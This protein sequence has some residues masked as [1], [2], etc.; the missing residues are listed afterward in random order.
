MRAPAVR[1]SPG[2]GPTT[3]PAPR[4]RSRDEPRWQ[5]R[6]VLAALLR[7]AVLATPLAAS[8]AVAFGAARLLGTPAGPGERA[9]WWGGVLAASLGALVVFDR[10]ARRLLPLAALLELSLI[11]PD[12]APSRFGV[13]LRSGSTGRLRAREVEA[14]RRGDQEPAD[15]ARTILALAA[16][17]SVHDRDTRGHS[18]RVRAY[19][20]L[21][22]AELGLDADDR[23]RLRWAALLHDLGKLTVAAHTLHAPGD[24]SHDEWEALR[25]HPIEGAR[26]A[27]PLRAWLGPWALAIEQHHERFDG[28]GYPYGLSGDRIS[29][30]ARIV[31]VADCYD[32]MTSPRS[33]RAPLSAAG[34]RQEL[35]AQA[36]SH[37]DPA[38]VRA[39]LSVSLGRLRWVMG[40]LAF[41]AAL[42]FAL[43]VAGVR[44]G[45]DSAA[46]T[47]ALGA[48]S[49]V[50]TVSIVSPPSL[51]AELGPARAPLERPSPA[52][53]PPAPT[54]ATT[55]PPVATTPPPA[56]AP[57]P[58]PA[59]REPATATPPAAAPA[60][61]APPTPAAAA[62]APA[63]AE[64]PPT[65]PPQTAPPATATAETVPPATAAECR[66]RA[67]EQSRRPCQPP[68]WGHTDDGNPTAT[69]R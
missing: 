21:I 25:R 14:L 9:L 42:P 51:G 31:A 5:H 62:E 32:A 6:P 20:D 50:A 16:S 18:E 30:G 64:A 13:A 45:L 44:R 33:Y 68:R 59:G 47:A 15:A 69:R 24:L 38:V 27:E 57:P 58:A 10:A 4:H 61:P 28:T 66:E 48:A 41:L 22:A 3:G 63:E 11:F 55:A 29:L 34:A 36:G 56:T 26:L 37:F 35:A 39:F 65:T 17:L 1:R 53:A 8:L 40:P 43:P 2:G 7:L 52:A 60:A 49:L 46:R 67:A 54:T 23:D 19:A 12:R